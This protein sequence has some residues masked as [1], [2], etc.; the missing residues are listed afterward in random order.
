L[1]TAFFCGLTPRLRGLL[2]S[3]FPFKLT[4]LR[5]FLRRASFKLDAVAPRTLKRFER[6]GHLD[7]ARGSFAP[8]LPLNCT[9]TAWRYH[10]PLARN[11][12]PH[13][14]TIG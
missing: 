3:L 14:P 5:D 11:R 4:L 9:R 13:P 2:S 10:G 7:L 8:A 6:S 12:R 1:R